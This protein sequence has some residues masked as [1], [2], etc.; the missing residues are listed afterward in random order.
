MENY[1]DFI[2]KKI[3]NNLSVN[4][5]KLI[6]NSHLHVGHRFYD[7]NKYHLKLEIDSDE[8]KKMTRIEAQKLVMK[9]LDQDMKNKIH[10]LE[11]LIK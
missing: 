8:L 7:K 9:I 10:A 11:I 2:T 4:T 5:L 1:L 6:D 3:K